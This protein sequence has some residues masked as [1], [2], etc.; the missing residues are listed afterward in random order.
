MANWNRRIQV[1]WTTLRLRCPNCGQGR[2]FT[3]LFKMNETCPYCGVRFER[4]S[5]ESVGAMYIALVV[6]ELLTM[7][8]FFL[9][10]ALFHPPDVPHLVFWVIF[11]VV[12]LTLFYRHARSLWVGT[13]YLTGGVFVD[14]DED[15]EYQRPD[16]P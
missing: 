16:A 6:V 15:K 9:V 4:E 8:G 2:I 1:W 11:D 3:G 7:G 13:T 14:P 10:N 5:G 12:F